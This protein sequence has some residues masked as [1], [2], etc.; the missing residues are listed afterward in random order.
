MLSTLKDFTAKS[1][2]QMIFIVKLK[3]GK[4]FSGPLSSEYFIFL[5]PV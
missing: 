2:N 4:I 3:A 1:V 5:C